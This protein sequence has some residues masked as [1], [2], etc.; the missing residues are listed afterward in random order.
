MNSAYIVLLAIGTA[1]SHDTGRRLEM[2]VLAPSK[3]E[4]AVIAERNGNVIVADDEYVYAKS[5]RP[6]RTR[7]FPFVHG[8]ELA[9]AI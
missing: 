8:P 6:A 4:A 7:R 2:P 1:M 5:I 9:V 3:L